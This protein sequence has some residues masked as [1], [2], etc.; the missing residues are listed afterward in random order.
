LNLNNEKILFEGICKGE[1]TTEKQG[2]EGFGYDPIFKPN[3]F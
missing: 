1:I 2:E 3:G